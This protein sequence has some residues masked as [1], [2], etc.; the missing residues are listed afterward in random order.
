MQRVQKVEK[1]QL[2]KVERSRNTRKPEWQM[3]VV[4]FNKNGCLINGD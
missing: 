4:E 2:K 3:S 1:T